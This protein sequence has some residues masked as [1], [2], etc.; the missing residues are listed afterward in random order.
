[1]LNSNV[2][3]LPGFD[4]KPLTKEDFRAVQ[5]LINEVVQEDERAL[6][7]AKSIVA[8]LTAFDIFKKLERT[9]GLP[10]STDS[11]LAYGGIVAQL[12]GCG[13]WILL[14]AWNNPQVLD[15]LE[16]RYE[17]ISARVKEL[18]WDDD[19]V[20]NPLSTSERSQI[21]AAFGMLIATSMS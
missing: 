1:M 17:D 2:E 20:E 19:W 12:K 10:T 11:K 18:S 3:S 21:D 14:A 6:K 8:W 13:K 9:I 4:D 16:L 7:L 5:I 15:Y